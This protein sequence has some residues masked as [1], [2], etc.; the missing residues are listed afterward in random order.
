[1]NNNRENEIKREDKKAFKS[2]AFI[3]FISAIVGGFMGAGAVYLKETLGDT[4]P[5]LLI[6]M[7]EVTTP[8]ANI[9][10]SVFLIIAYNIVYRSSRKEYELWQERNEE[11]DDY[12]IVDKI[13]EKLSYILLFTSIST[14]LGFFFF[15]IGLML[16]PFDK[17]GSDFNSVKFVLFLIG[18]LL[19]IASAILIQKKIVNFEKEINP[20]LKGSIYDVKFT[21]KWLDSCDEAMQLEIYKS[22]YKANTTVSTTCIILWVFCVL[23]YNVWDF[24]IMPM[25]IVIIIWLVQTVSYCMESVKISKSKLK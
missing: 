22:A 3:I 4:I 15:G 8:F 18:F 19:N 21:E 6:N 25:V 20:L 9:V 5:N 14:I 23:G 11:N 10:L 13:E 2:F 7:L 12:D 1:M 17:V 24:G 16:S